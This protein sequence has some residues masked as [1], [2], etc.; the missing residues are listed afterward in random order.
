MILTNDGIVCK[1]VLNRISNKGH[2]ALQSDNASYPTYTIPA[3]E[4][5][6][7]W[8]VEMKMSAILRNENLDILKRINTLEGD[9]AEL[10][11]KKK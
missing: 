3:S 10:K 4:I 2:L 11:A 5:L 8:R 7:I 9:V 1:R 6:S